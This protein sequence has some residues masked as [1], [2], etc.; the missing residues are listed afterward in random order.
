MKDKEVFWWRLCIPKGRKLFGF[1]WRI[2]F[3]GNGRLKINCTMWLWLWVIWVKG[4][5]GVWSGIYGYPYLNNIN[6]FF[7]KN[8][9]GQL[10]KLNES[11]GE[12]N[13]Y[14]EVMGNIWLVW[15]NL[16]NEFWKCI[17]CILSAFAYDKKGYRIC[18]ITNRK[19]YGKAEETIYRDVHGKTDVLNLSFPPYRLH[20]ITFATELYYLKQLHWLLGVTLST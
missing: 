10:S 19:Y 20:Y 8:W 18:K 3:L 12:K 11:I 15:K 1:V 4:W 7:P 17:G 13:R 2:T 6:E 16:N 9:F 5:R 14:H